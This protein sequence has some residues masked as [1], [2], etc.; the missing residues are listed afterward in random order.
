MGLR[1]LFFVL[2]NALGSLEYL[3]YGLGVILAFIGAKM[4]LSFFHI[5]V[6]VLMSLVF[7]LVVLLITVVASRYI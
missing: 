4:F 5:E 6:P 2:H 7:I 1:S 3:K